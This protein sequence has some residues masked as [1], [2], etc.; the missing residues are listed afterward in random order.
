MVAASTPTGNGYNVGALEERVTG[1]ERGVAAIGASVDRLA[2]E[3]RDR[4]KFPWGAASFALGV[5]GLLGA[6]VVFGFM[7]YI[8]AIQ[9]S[10]DRLQAQLSTWID[11]S[12]SRSELEERRAATAT[13]FDR[14][15]DAVLRLTDG[16]VTRGEHESKWDAE[17][18]SA[19]N[20]QRQIDQIR[21]DLGSSFSLNDA[22]KDISDRIARLEELR[23]QMSVGRNPSS[24]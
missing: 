14:L 8:G 1:L 21:T 5:L 11:N 20:L 19:S 23:L 3:V 2:N 15:E 16:I 22:L 7:A 9:G 17:T 4:Q 18:A 10:Q 13:R 6:V 12:V 24:P